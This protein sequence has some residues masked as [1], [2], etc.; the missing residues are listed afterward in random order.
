[1]RMGNVDANAGLRKP[2]E[3]KVKANKKALADK[4]RELDMLKKEQ[5]G[6][7]AERGKNMANNPQAAPGPD[8]YPE[9][10]KTAQTAVDA[11]KKELEAAEKELAANDQE[12]GKKELDAPKKK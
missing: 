11:A 4:E 6:F 12:T 7:Y 1:M 2:A 8:P 10:L 5:E 3:D 9:R